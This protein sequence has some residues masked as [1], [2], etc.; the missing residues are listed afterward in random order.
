M[1]GTVEVDI[2]GMFKPGKFGL[3][4]SW[5]LTA[6]VKAARNCG[7]FLLT[8]SESKFL[9]YVSCGASREETTHERKA[10]S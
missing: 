7:S 9:M 4:Q 1:E 2:S 8:E 10:A 6:A 5:V 3:I